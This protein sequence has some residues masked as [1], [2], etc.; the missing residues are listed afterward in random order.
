MPE[1]Y[2]DDRCAHTGQSYEWLDREERQPHEVWLLIEKNVKTECL[3]GRDPSTRWSRW[4]MPIKREIPEEPTLQDAFKEQSDKWSCETQHLSSPTQ[5]MMHPSYLAIMGMAK[6]HKDDVIRLML[7]DLK[8]HRRPWF[9]AL[10]YLT[11]DNPI[12]LGDAGKLD[13]MIKSWIEWGNRRG[14]L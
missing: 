1:T 2:S 3:P 4:G 13:K 5:M 7:R 10:S 9:W 14:I 8:E 6:E 11:T 12:K